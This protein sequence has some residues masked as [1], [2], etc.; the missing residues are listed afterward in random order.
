MRLNV[1]LI[2]ID[3]W[4]LLSWLGLGKCLLRLGRVLGTRL[5]W[6]LQLDLDGYWG[7]ATGHGLVYRLWVWHRL[8]DWLREGR[9][10]VLGLHV[11]V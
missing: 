5:G 6:N 10:L 7:L 3:C 1:A 8:V 11:S 9:R 2:C 4:I